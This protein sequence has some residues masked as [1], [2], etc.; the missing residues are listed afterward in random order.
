V[1]ESFNPFSDRL[2][3]DIRNSLSTSFVRSVAVMDPSEIIECVHGHLQEDLAPP[4]LAYIEDRSR[5]LC[6]GFM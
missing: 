4:H 3:R 6:V 1:I 5:R 2:S